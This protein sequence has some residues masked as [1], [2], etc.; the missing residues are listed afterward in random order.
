[1][2]SFNGKCLQEPR[3][4]EEVLHLR[5]Y[6]AYEETKTT[7]RTKHLNRFCLSSLSI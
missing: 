2:T 7:L 1:M 5:A 3:K 6:A 4:K